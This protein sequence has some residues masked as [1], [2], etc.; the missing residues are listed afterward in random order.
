[1]EKT[2][3]WDLAIVIAK[4]LVKKGLE[5]IQSLT[6]EDLLKYDSEIQN[7]KDFGKEEDDDTLDYFKVLIEFHHTLTLGK[8][9]I[10]EPKGELVAYD[11][12]S[13][14]DSDYYCLSEN[15]REEFCSFMES[16]GDI[17]DF[18]V[19]HNLKVLR[20]DDEYER[21]IELYE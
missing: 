15:L 17:V 3:M 9:Y 6:K 10:N 14:K 8:L 2:K 19:D 13:D 1:M 18:A 7:L 16:G 21:R 5:E 12:L 11:I 4:D 20:I